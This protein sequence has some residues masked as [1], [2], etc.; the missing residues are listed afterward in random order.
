VWRGAAGP[1][2]V[3]AGEVRGPTDLTLRPPALTDPPILTGLPLLLVDSMPP[4]TGAGRHGRG[5]DKGGRGDPSPPGI[6]ADHRPGIARTDA[7]SSDPA[8]ARPARAGAAAF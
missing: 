4:Q 7:K 6:P 2:S 1:V 5:E 8:A 3:T